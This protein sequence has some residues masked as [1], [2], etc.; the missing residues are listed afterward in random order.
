MATVAGVR[1][2]ASDGALCGRKRGDDGGRGT[3]DAAGNHLPC[4]FHR[5]RLGPR[6]T[7]FSQTLG[8]SSRR[9]GSSMDAPRLGLE[10]DLAGE[11]G[12]K[13]LVAADLYFLDL[14]LRPQIHGHGSD[15]RDVDV[16]P[17]MLAGAL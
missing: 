6:A 3:N 5:R 12:V 10:S 9:V 4:R 14:D 8:P 1:R 17:A 7:S 15:E 16:E 11:E 13:L 2:E